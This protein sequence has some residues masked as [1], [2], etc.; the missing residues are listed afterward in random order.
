MNASLAGSSS[1]AASGSGSCSPA[2]WDFVP[3]LA[4]IERRADA[5][6]ER[7]PE[8]AAELGAGF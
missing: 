7:D 5:A 8:C 4:A 3:D 1:S 6:E 2:R